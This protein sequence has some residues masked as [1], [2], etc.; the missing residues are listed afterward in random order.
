MI[1]FETQRR[2]M[3]EQSGCL[4]STKRSSTV[5]FVIKFNLPGAPRWSDQFK[6]LI[7]VIIGRIRGGTNLRNLDLF[8]FHYQQLHMLLK[9]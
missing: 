3:Q 7:G 4:G 1:Y 9:K 6:W 8:K 5:F 2:L